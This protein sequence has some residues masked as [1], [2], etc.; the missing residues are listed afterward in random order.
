MY[1]IIAMR[2]F[3]QL[4]IPSDT[5]I[6]DAQMLTFEPPNSAVNFRTITHMKS[7]E[8]EKFCGY[9]AEKCS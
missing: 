1:V 3:T 6:C 2:M 4:R 7:F 9:I 5:S 8:G